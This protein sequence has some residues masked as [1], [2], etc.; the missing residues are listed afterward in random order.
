M[1]SSSSE[2]FNHMIYILNLCEHCLIWTHVPFSL[3]VRSLC[4]HSSPPPHTHCGVCGCEQSGFEK[5]KTIPTSI[6]FFFSARLKTPPS[7]FR[8]GGWAGW[9][10]LTAAFTSSC[11]QPKLSKRE[12]RSNRAH[13]SLSLSLAPRGRDGGGGEGGVGWGG[14]PAEKERSGSKQQRSLG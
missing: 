13:A 6:F 9:F 11:V 12:N 3:C 8:S 5:K 14:R 10:R 7:G 4:I 2:N 1:S